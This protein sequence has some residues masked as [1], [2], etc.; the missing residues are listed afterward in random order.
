MKIIRRII[1]RKKINLERMKIEYEKFGE[2]Q[3]TLQLCTDKFLD[4][5]YIIRSCL[6]TASFINDFSV[7][8]RTTELS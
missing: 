8:R 2:F 3:V 6:K 5:D 1:V 7:I 4:L